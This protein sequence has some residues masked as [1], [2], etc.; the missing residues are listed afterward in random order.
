[1][2]F[3][4]IFSRVCWLGTSL[5]KTVVRLASLDR[6]FSLKHLIPGKNKADIFGVLLY[7]LFST[8]YKIPLCQK[9][10]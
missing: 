1:V 4:T 3:V 2:Y 5:S 10:S 6:R 7:I 8:K 9:G